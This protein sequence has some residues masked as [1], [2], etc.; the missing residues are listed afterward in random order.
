MALISY[1]LI[2]MCFIH[3]LITTLINNAA[4]LNQELL[5]IVNLYCYFYYPSYFWYNKL[6]VCCRKC[7]I[8]CTACTFRLMVYQIQLACAYKR[9]SYNQGHVNDFFVALV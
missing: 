4:N 7:L 1:D 3:N 6:N 2:K 8:F 5:N 9:R